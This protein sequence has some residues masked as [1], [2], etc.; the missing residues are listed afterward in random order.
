MTVRNVL[1][2]TYDLFN[3]N[4]TKRI[5]CMK[6]LSAVALTVAAKMAQKKMH[7]SYYNT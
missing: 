2:N 1:F 5:W 4:G 6:C 3:T 7:A